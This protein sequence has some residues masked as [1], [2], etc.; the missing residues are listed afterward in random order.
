MDPE[1]GTIIFFMSHDHSR[2]WSLI[3]EKYEPR[4]FILNPQKYEPRSLMS[5]RRSFPITIKNISA[6]KIAF[7]APKFPIFLQNVSVMEQSGSQDWGKYILDKNF[8]RELCWTCKFFPQKNTFLISNGWFWWLSCDRP[9][10]A[11][12]YI[13]WQNHEPQ[14]LT[15]MIDRI[16]KIWATITHDRQ[17]IVNDRRSR[18]D[19]PISASM[20]GI[21]NFQNFA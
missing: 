4:S 11:I 10:S 1:I 5:D 18:S 21:W 14:S 17:M 6:F 7:L 13:H 9:W 15:I 20:D 2:S 3:M 19:H 16:K 8:K 12:I